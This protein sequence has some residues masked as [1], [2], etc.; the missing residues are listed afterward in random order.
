MISQ[1]VAYDVLTAALASGGDFAEIFIE[2]TRRNAISLVNGGVE[3][4]SSVITHGC[5]IRVFIAAGGAYGAL[6]SYT[7]DTSA[8]SLLRL[9]KSMAKDGACVKVPPFAVKA[10]ENAHIAEK[11]PGSVKNSDIARML[12]LAHE[13][14][15]SY[16]PLVTQTAC[17]YADVE[18]NV[19]IINSEGL[20]AEDKR[21]R[22]R[23]SAGA[24]ATLAGEKQSAVNS[25]G[26]SAGLEIFD[27]YDM[28]Q[29]AEQSARSA[30][31]IV[32]AKRC[33]VGVMPVVIGDGFGGVIFHEACGHALEA[34]SVAKNAS[35]FAGKLG[36]AIAS[37]LVTAVD[38]GTIPGEW[39]SLNIDDEG[40]RTRKNTL[41]ENGVLKSYMVDKLNGRV[42]GMAPTGSSRRES[43]RFAP[44]SR[45]TNTYIASGGSSFDDIISATPYGLY[46]KKMGGGSVQPA[47]GDFNFFVTEAY[48]IRDGKIAEPVRGATLI[49]K[50]SKT[51]MD[52]D[53][54]SDGMRME[55]GVCGSISGAVPTNVGQP[56]IRVKR[57][58]VGGRG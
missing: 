58:T 14:A 55:Q 11:Y 42:M 44:T 39:G 9:A 35:V 37:P 57:L 16:D 23:V 18:Q 40:E 29:L 41:I 12:T 2:T 46:A 43:Y 54:V 1:S 36:E 34:T 6:Y 38:D 8:E 31:T 15:S 32:K 21:V 17:T 20:W 56:V 53:M 52:I 22:A 4:A 45:M 5:G 26:A 19:A 50:G 28:E 13:R 25:P 30:V 3:R 33:P 48:L 51:L 49:G 10:V 24:T 47:T 7:N 27:M